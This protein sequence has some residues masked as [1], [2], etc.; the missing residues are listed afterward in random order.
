MSLRRHPQKPHEPPLPVSS[1][2][3]KEF[4]LMTP[5]SNVPDIARYVMPACP[6]HESPFLK[7]NFQGQKHH[8]KAKNRLILDLFR[9]EYNYFPWSDPK[10]R[11]VP[12]YD[13]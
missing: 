9:P 13:V 7:Q 5:M 1:K 8:S 3:Q 2:L 10:R 6:R 4:L 11:G 12:H